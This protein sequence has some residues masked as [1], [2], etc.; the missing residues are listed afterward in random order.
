MEEKIDFLENPFNGI[1][2][3][4]VIGIQKRC[5]TMAEKL[6]CDYGIKCGDRT[7]RL[8]EIE[9]YYY[10]NN[11]SSNDNWDAPWNKE[12]YPRNK[13]AGEF[14]FHYSGVDI[15]FQCHFVEKARD[16]EY[17]EFGGILIRSLLDGDRIIAGPLFCANTMMNTCNNE[18]PR[19]VPCTHQTCEWGKDIRCG[20]NSDKKQESDKKLFLCYY[21]KYVNNKEIQWDKVSEKI[22]WDK[23]NEKF[24]QSTRNYKKERGFL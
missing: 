9:F 23:K 15:C 10:K 4:D 3:S 18:L 2:S 17:G 22:S 24:K 19:L 13:K 8:A 7:F 5:T 20:I 16:N 12:T 14:F 21:A 1:K 11:E 6:F